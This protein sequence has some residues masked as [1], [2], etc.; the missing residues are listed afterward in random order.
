MSSRIEIELKMIKLR[1]R[2]IRLKKVIVA[3]VKCRM[4]KRHSNSSRS[5]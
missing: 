3:L 2:K 5:V 1:G 4:S